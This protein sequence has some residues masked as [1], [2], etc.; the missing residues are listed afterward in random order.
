LKPLNRGTI[1]LDEIGEM[2]PAMQV[3]LLRVLQERKGPSGR[4]ARRNPIDARVIAAT[5]RD[6][7]E[8]VRRRLVP[9]RFVLPHFGHPDCASA[10]SRTQG[11]HS[12]LVGH[13][14]KKF[15][16]QTGDSL[17]ITPKAMQIAGKLRVARQRPRA[18]THDRTRRR[19]RT[20]RRNPAR[21]LPEHITNYNPDAHQ[22]EFDL[23]DD[24]INMTTHLENL[25]KDL[26]Y[27]SSETHRR[28]PDESR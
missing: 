10:A 15:C 16:D 24:G 23:P 12:D 21:T 26:R 27:G 25:E 20:H 7:K 11:G 3:K 17:S 19:A 14:M 28:K 1:F 5:N 6:L 4:R 13:F 2:S 8:D 22:N 9:R 18:R